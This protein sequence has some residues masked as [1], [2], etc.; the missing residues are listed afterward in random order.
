MQTLV[1]TSGLPPESIRAVSV[2]DASAERAAA[3]SHAVNPKK[4]KASG[5]RVVLA[6]DSPLVNPVAIR[7]LGSCDAVLLLVDQGR[8]VI[9]D[10]RRTHDL[11]GPERVLGAVFVQE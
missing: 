10:A 8:S 9:P 5:Q 11:I 6:T 1:Q 3:I 4:V 7:V 2:L